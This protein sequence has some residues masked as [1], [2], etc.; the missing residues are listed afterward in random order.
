[1]HR[2]HLIVPGGGV[3]ETTHSQP[4]GK[5]GSSLTHC[6]GVQSTSSKSV[7]SQYISSAHSVRPDAK[8]RKFRLPGWLVKRSPI[9]IAEH[10]FS[11]YS[12]SIS[13]RNPQITY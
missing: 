10:C 7:S 12:L 11:S 1:M 5:V 4:S 2:S 13:V 3:D 8:V 6:K 9:L